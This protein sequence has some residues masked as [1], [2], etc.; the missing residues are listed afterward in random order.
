MVT[1]PVSF[2]MLVSRNLVISEYPAALSA[3]VSTRFGIGVPANDT[4]GSV[5]AVEPSWPVRV[6]EDS[7]SDGEV[8]ESPVAG[9]VPARVQ[10]STLCSAPFTR[11]C[12]VMPVSAY[13]VQNVG[14]VTV[15]AAFC[16]QVRSVGASERTVLLVVKFT[17]AAGVTP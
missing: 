7:H 11:D 16:A 14:E 10:E 15:Q 2:A 3:E 4:G 12:V 1:A 13:E 8:V 9:Y 5:I 6:T 17:W